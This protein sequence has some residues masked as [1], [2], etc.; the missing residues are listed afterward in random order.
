MDT[1]CKLTRWCV[2]LVLCITRFVGIHVCRIDNEISLVQALLDRPST[3]VLAEFRIDRKITITSNAKNVLRQD[4]PL[5]N[6]ININNG[7]R[8][9]NRRLI[10]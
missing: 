1:D 7:S 9:D 4:T 8:L 6:G 2:A 3:M 5:A 10:K